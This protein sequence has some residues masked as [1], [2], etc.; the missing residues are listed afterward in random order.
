VQ[1]TAYSPSSLTSPKP[2]AETGRRLRTLP[3]PQGRRRP[4][5]TSPAPP[6]KAW[7]RPRADG[8]ARN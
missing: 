5:P 1:Y 7:S 3:S 4:H 2:A 6:D 8:L